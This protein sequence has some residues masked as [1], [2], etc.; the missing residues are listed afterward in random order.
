MTVFPRTGATARATSPGLSGPLENTTATVNVSVPLD[1][2]AIL[3]AS[4]TFALVASLGTG[5]LY[6]EGEEVTHVR[7]AATFGGPS[8]VTYITASGKE[9]P[10]EQFAWR[11]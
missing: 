2:P 8:T 3:A 9:V 4:A 10:A 5:P 6:A 7:V 11:W 1:Q